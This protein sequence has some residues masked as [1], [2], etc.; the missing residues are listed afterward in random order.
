[1]QGHI[2]VNS[3]DNKPFFNAILIFTN[4]QTI[5]HISLQLY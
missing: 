5:N 2:L 3:L 4:I 1:M